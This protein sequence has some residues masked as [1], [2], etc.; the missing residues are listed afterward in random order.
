MIP[1][2]YNP[3]SREFWGRTLFYLS[4]RINL[5]TGNNGIIEKMLPELSPW[6]RFLSL[7]SPGWI[8]VRRKKAM[9]LVGFIILVNSFIT[10]NF[11]A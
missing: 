10:V 2:I 5:T 1:L 6:L 11:P 7:F 9:C 4:D 8:W 3:E